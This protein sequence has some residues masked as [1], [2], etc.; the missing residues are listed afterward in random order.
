MDEN[1]SV[2]LNTLKLLN[3][4]VISVTTYIDVI[5]LTFLLL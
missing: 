3:F 4:I 2:C 1:L 5:F